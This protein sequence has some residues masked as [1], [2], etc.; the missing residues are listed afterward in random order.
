M[1]QTWIILGATSGMARCFA[2]DM[3]DRGDA[4][5]LQDPA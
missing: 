5:L 4:L 1:S 2:R 3:A